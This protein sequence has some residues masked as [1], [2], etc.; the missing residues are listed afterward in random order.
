[1]IIQEINGQRV[2][3]PTEPS[4]YLCNAEIQV[5]T[6]WIV[7]AKESDGS[8]WTE[9]TEEEKQALEKEWEAE[10]EADT[11]ATEQ[12]YQNALAEMGV[13]L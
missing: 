9:I 2:G 3:T 12:D 13:E 5:I 8:E 7:L 1:M 10:T 11:Q 6:E 4:N